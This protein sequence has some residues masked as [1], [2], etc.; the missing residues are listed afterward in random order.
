LGDGSNGL[1]RSLEPRSRKSSNGKSR[2]NPQKPKP[3]PVNPSIKGHKENLT[4]ALRQMQRGSDV[5]A[6]ALKLYQRLQ[7]NSGD[8]EVSNL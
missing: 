3:T 6:A 5:I 1:E 4:L 7:S 2:L 8:N